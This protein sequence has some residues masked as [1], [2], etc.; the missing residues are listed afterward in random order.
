VRGRRVVILRPLG[1]GDFLTGIPA[2]RAIARAFPGHRIVLAA[3]AALAALLDFGCGIDELQ[4]TRPLEPLH[5]A[6][7]DADI[8]VDLHGRGPESHRVL[9]AAR[10]RRLIAFHNASIPQSAAGAEW[11]AAEHEVARWCRMLSHAGIPADPS[12][13]DLDVR[14]RRMPSTKRGFTILHPGAASEAR[15]WPVNRW[16]AVAHA[17]HSAGRRVVITGSR[18]ERARAREIADRAGL[19]PRSVL[20][21]RTDLRQLTALVSSAGVVV[22][23]DTGVAHLATALRIPSVLL[24]GPMSPALW[25]PP[26]E[27]SYRRVLWHGGSGNPH[28]SSVDPAL[29]KISVADVLEALHTSRERLDVAV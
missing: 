21:G 22:C 20:A 29:L 12:D 19:S 13:L 11:I 27:R 23:G 18:S 15:R 8:A 3:P 6:L 7:H 14:P 1:L 26:P 5:P 24:F 10:P 28:G 4:A 9:L 17:E 16:A 25:G 2:Y